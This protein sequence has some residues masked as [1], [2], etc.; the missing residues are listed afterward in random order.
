MRRGQAG[1]CAGTA[2]APSSVLRPALQSVTPQ[3]AARRYQRGK[4]I[5]VNSFWNT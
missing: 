4:R 3:A 5:G 2:Q 1:F